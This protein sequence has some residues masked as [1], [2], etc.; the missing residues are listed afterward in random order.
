[1]HLSSDT[2]AGDL[3]VTNFIQGVL[4]Y[5][6]PSATIELD[7]RTGKRLPWRRVMNPPLQLV[8]WIAGLT[9]RKK[10]FWQVFL[11]SEDIFFP[12]LG[13]KSL[14][15]K[16]ARAILRG[17]FLSVFLFLITWSLSVAILC[18]IYCGKNIGSVWAPQVR[19]NFY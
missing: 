16:L 17:L 5:L 4:N 13:F 10:Q 9:G 3:A 14:A 7:N 6:V 11:Q 19:Q 8:E 1:M 18:P 15:K 2:I 12:P